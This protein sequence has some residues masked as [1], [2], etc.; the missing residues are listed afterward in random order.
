MGRVPLYQ[1]WSRQIWSG[2]MF[3]L[4]TVLKHTAAFVRGKLLSLPFAKRYHF[5][6]SM[7]PLNQAITIGIHTTYTLFKLLTVPAK[8]R[9][10]F[11]YCNF[12]TTRGINFLVVS[13]AQCERTR[14]HSINHMTLSYMQDY[15][16]DFQASFYRSEIT[17]ACEFLCGVSELWNRS[18]WF[19]LTVFF[20]LF[21]SF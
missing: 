4:V 6:S 5:P 11:F 13:M 14:K 16:R 18:L 20:S 3:N 9:L 10:P 19:K 2:K 7:H 17:F 12:W 15:C 8:I 1:I 21:R